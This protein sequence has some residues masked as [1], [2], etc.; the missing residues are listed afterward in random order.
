V[1]TRLVLA[2]AVAAVSAAGVVS[3]SASTT[4]LPVTVTRDNGGVQVRS[5][6]PG[7]PLVG[8]SADDDGVC[9][10]FSLQ[11]PACVPVSAG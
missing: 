10:G 2:A 1:R 6:V 7:Q 4:E 3:A 5:G 8:A 11:M 9:V